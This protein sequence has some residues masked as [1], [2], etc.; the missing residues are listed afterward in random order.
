MQIQGSTF[1]VTGGASGLGE[2]TVRML[3]AAGAHVV[4]A[5]LQAEKGEALV[6]AL[7]S[8]RFV[9]CDVTNE[10]D[11]QAAETSWD[12]VRLDARIFAL[13]SAISLAPISW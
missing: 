2:G 1:I 10:A 6:K 7:P 8:A 12:T 13:R 4:I 9:R 3:A 5:D 11:A